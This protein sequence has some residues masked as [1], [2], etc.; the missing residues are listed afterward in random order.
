[1]FY[2]KYATFPQGGVFSQINYEFYVKK[3][4]LRLKKMLWTNTPT[5][6]PGE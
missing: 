4:D 5:S 6:F 3:A 1:M 2:N